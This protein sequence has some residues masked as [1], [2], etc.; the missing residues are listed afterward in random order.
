MSPAAPLTCSRSQHLSGPKPFP[1]TKDEPSSD[2][3]GRDQAALTGLCLLSLVDSSLFQCRPGCD[4]NG[5]STRPERQRGKSGGPAPTMASLQQQPRRAREGDSGH[6][7]RGGWDGRG[8]PP[9]G[10]D[11]LRPCPVPSPGDAGPRRPHPPA[12]LV[13]GRG[14]DSAHRDASRG[15]PVIEVGDLN[16]SFLLVAPSRVPPGWPNPRPHQLGAP[17]LASRLGSRAPQPPSVP[18]FVSVGSPGRAR[19]PGAAG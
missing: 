8:G 15:S 6:P 3:V 19:P 13:E 12:E 1:S 17:G 9:A 11:G 18:A 4:G 5:W 7:D 16:R 14:R 10:E 2:L